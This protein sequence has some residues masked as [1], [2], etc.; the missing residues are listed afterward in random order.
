MEDLRLTRHAV[1]V[2]PLGAAG[3]T[4]FW[5]DRRVAPWLGTPG[6]QAWLTRGVH[7]GDL[8]RI[9]V[10]GGENISAERLTGEDNNK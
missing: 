10:S 8:R 5:I 9:L 6:T 2:A 1:R 7:P 4:R 3:A